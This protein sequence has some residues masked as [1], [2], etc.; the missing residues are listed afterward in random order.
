MSIVA[1][2]ADWE[3]R[4]GWLRINP[5]T[6]R[7]EGEF[8]SPYDVLFT[9]N[10]TSFKPLAAL[11]ASGIPIPYETLPGYPW[12]YVIDYSVQQAGPLHVK[13]VVKYKVFEDPLA[14][15]P[16]IRWSFGSDTDVVDKAYRVKSNVISGIG[17]EDETESAVTNSALEQPDP[18]MMKEYHDLMMMVTVNRQ[19]Y[20]HKAAA[21]YIDAVN[22]DYFYGFRPGRVRCRR[23]DGDSMRAGALEYWQHTLEFQIRTFNS[24]PLNIG[25]LRRFQDQ[26]FHERVETE[27]GSGVYE[28]RAIGDWLVELD[29]DGNEAKRTF[30][31]VSKPAPLDLFGKKLADGEA[32]KFLEW[33]DYDLLPFSHFG[34]GSGLE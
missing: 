24:D 2:T 18:P 25:W 34:L 26:G 21:E 30:K 1:V 16:V 14:I 22:S 8:E 7:P 12:V 13:V 19:S 33:R 32:V 15:P 29:D 6:L 17:Y 11:Y 5:E 23:Y 3:N 27:T 4:K 9:D 10:D 31:P 20:D 28:L